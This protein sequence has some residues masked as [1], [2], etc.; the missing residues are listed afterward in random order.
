MWVKFLLRMNYLAKCDELLITDTPWHTNHTGL[1]F[2]QNRSNTLRSSLSLTVS[3]NYTDPFLDCYWNNFGV[4]ITMY[5]A[6]LQRLETFLVCFKLL[7]PKQTTYGKSIYSYYKQPYKVRNLRSQREST[8]D[9]CSNGHNSP[10][11]PTL[12]QRHRVALGC[13]CEEWQK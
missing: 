12:S 2:T 9:N 11:F 7:C 1:L 10:H 13:T 6:F 4:T 8:H 3:Q 5:F